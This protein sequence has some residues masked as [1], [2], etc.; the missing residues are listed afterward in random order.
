VEEA[1][2]EKNEKIEEMARENAGKLKRE[3]EECHRKV[4][5]AESE[6]DQTVHMNQKDCNAKLET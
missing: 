6:R 4:A 2:R 5:A 1:V 3:T